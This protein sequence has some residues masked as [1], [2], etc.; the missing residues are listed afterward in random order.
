M[1]CP[2][3]FL[4]RVS[5]AN[6]THGRRNNDA[7][8]HGGNPHS[9]V[10]LIPGT[11]HNIII[12]ETGCMAEKDNRSVSDWKKYPAIYLDMIEAWLKILE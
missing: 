7:L 2:A 5:E 6:Y 9:C 10:E 1:V 3:D 12:S 4:C 11:D 8:R